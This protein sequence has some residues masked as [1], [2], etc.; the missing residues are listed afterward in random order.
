MKKTVLAAACIMLLAVVPMSAQLPSE[1][2][3]GDKD[4]VKGLYQKYEN[5]PKVSSIYISAEMIR[6]VSLLGDMAGDNVSGTVSVTGGDS[7]GIEDIDVA[8]VFSIL[9]KL[10]GLYLLSTEDVPTAEAMEKD[11]GGVGRYKELMRVKDS[12]DDLRFYYIS[13]D[14]EYIEE[15]LMKANTGEGEFTVIQFQADSLTFQDIAR[16]AAEMSR[17]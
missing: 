13:P 9:G 8:Q 5:N 3:S 14:G 11:L 16:F 10:K 2:P 17:E 12:G 1:L 6:L 4:P 7:F 15:F